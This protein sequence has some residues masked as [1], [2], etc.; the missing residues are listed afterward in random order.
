LIFDYRTRDEEVP[1][2][3][4]CGHNAHWK[5]WHSLQKGRPC[6]LCRAERAESELRSLRTYLGHVADEASAEINSTNPELMIS[7]QFGARF[8]LAQEIL[9]RIDHQ[10]PNEKS[11]AEACLDL[12]REALVK[13]GVT[14]DHSP[15]MLYP[16]AIHN[17]FIWGIQAGQECLKKHGVQNQEHQVECISGWIAEHQS[18][19]K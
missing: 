9:K 18:I 8:R 14:M 13:H 6:I 15:A 10:D 1:L 16:E 5:I 12:I 7:A 11:D 19:K 3:L 17:L 2:F 4:P